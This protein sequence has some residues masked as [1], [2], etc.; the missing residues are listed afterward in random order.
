MGDDITISI[1]NDF[2]PFPAGRTPGDGDYNGQVFR[3]NILLPKL[4][5]AI[6]EGSHLLVSLDGLKSCG[7]SFLDSAFGGLVRYEKIDKQ[8]LNKTLRVEFTSHAL[9]RYNVAIEKYIL[10]AKPE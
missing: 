3:E 2:W 1:A 9:E 8:L 4:M 5:K 10:R 7:S 6:A